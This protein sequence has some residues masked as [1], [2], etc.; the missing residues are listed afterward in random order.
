[1]IFKR[2]SD[3]PHIEGNSS[4]TASK[5]VGR[6]GARKGSGRK[7]K[8]TAP[9]LTDIP[10]ASGQSAEALAKQ[11]VDIAM[12]T[13]VHIALNGESEA[14]RVSAADKIINRAAGMPKPGTAPRA[15]QPD[16]FEG[17]SDGWGDL[18][19]ARQQAPGRTN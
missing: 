16:M 6:G 13:L 9:P 12:A 3:G 19:K 1:L 2:I 14:A 4:V 15:D 7:K 10:V 8:P 5:N 18:L 11:N 17:D